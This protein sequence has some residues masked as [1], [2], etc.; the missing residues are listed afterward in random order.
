MAIPHMRFGT[1]ALVNLT[2]HN[3]ILK[4]VTIPPSGFVARA[5]ITR[6]DADP[7]GDI[8]VHVLEIGDVEGVPET[9][10][11]ELGDDVAFVASVIA[12]TA[13]RREWA[14][15]PVYAVDDVVRDRQTGAVLGANALS[16]PY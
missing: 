8:P 2:P 3:I 10:D 1:T 4:G 14:N 16:I 12:A 5:P 7:I 6:H 15:W 9:E 13:M 11:L